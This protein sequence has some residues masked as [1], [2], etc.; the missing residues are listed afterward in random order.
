MI[1]KFI[2]GEGEEPIMSQKHN[3]LNVMKKW[4]ISWRGVGELF[5]SRQPLKVLNKTNKYL[6]MQI[7]KS[8]EKG[9]K[10]SYIRVT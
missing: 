9:G 3:L 6:L 8:E 10:R 5:P 4:L 2:V 1:N 7:N